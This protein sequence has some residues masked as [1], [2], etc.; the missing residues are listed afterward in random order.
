MLA[1]L[2]GGMLGVIH[3][4]FSSGNWGFAPNPTEFFIRNEHGFA[5]HS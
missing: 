5:T 4:A 3:G 1:V 2:L